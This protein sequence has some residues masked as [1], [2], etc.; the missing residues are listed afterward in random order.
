MR[1]RVPC[2]SAVA[3]LGAEAAFTGLTTDA[4]TPG[5]PT[6]G[7]TLAGVAGTLAVRCTVWPVPSTGL[8]TVHLTSLTD[9]SA[10]PSNSSWV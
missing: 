8:S 7:Q 3:V 5:R 1:L 10:S 4:S 6:V 9:V 2:V